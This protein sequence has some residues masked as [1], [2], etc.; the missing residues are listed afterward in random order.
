MGFIRGVCCAVGVGRRGRFLEIGRSRDAA[1]VGFWHVQELRPPAGRFAFQNPRKPTCLRRSHPKRWRCCAA[2]TR[3]AR[4]SRRSRRRPASSRSTPSTNYKCLHGQ[5][6]DGSGA[7][8]PLPG[9]PRRRETLPTVRSSSRRRSLVARIW[10]NAEAQVEKIEAR[11]AQHEFAP[12]V[13]ERD[14]R[15]LAVLVRLR[16]LSVFADMRKP[17]ARRGP[18][19]SRE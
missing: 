8:L 11:L 15:A 10:K 5:F 9:V 16:E 1:S 18:P 17:S 13:V 6:D 7:P 3:T 14:A 12:K 4:Q 2:C 19:G